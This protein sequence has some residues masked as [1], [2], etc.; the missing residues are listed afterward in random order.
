MALSSLMCALFVLAVG[1]WSVAL[2]RNGRSPLGE[3]TM[4]LA[5]VPL[6]FLLGMPALWVAAEYYA[7]PGVTPNLGLV[8]AVFCWFQVVL[9]A[10][11]GVNAP[12]WRASAGIQL[13]GPG[14]SGIATIGVLAVAIPLVLQGVTAVQEPTEFRAHVS[15]S[16]H[17]AEP[18]DQIP[19][20]FA[21]QWTYAKK[22][23]E[24]DWSKSSMIAIVQGQ[25]L[26]V[27]RLPALMP[28][29]AK[30]YRRYLLDGVR[31]STDG[32]TQ[33]G[34]MFLNSY[35][36]SLSLGT[37]TYDPRIDTYFDYDYCLWRPWHRDPLTT[38]N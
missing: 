38:G 12:R 20:D 34:G 29:G 6:A 31:A 9:I 7:W 13:A 23:E 14:M 2:A 10:I 5:I 37:V 8:L 17:K 28:A 4:I 36:S 11:A 32:G 24:P 15:S 16:C 18:R 33:V 27:I 22:G 21:L 3:S 30:V 1:E 19:E 25:P 35:L 26:D